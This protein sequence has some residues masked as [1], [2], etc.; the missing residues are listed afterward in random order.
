MPFKTWLLPHYR[1]LRP[2]LAKLALA[3]TTA[4]SLPLD[5]ALARWLTESSWHKVLVAEHA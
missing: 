3:L 1:R 5:C 2:P 4:V